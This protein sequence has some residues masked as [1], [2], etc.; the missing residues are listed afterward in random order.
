MNKL[1]QLLD[2]GTKIKSV[3]SANNL[4]LPPYSHILLVAG[5]VLSIASSVEGQVAAKT[6]KATKRMRV[7]VFVCEHGA[8]KG[9][10]AAAHFNKLASDRNL[11]VRAISR[12]TNPDEELAPKAVEGLRAEGLPV[13]REQ[14]TRLSKGDV[15]KA[16]LVVAFC[17]LPEAYRKGRRVEQWNDVP[18]V[19]EDYTKARDAIV[20]RVKQLLDELGSPK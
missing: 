18:S 13:V 3:F 14:P 1:K 5:V 15:S 16:D 8:A 6:R 19:S 9:V 12:G 2:S 20:E 17:E 10:I 11:N 7:I 4:K